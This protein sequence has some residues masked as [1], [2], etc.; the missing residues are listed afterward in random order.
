M[1]RRELLTAAVGAAVLAAVPRL[2]PAHTPY[3]QWL[4]YRKR[5]LLILA[6][7][8][9]AGAF[10]LARA[11]AEALAD[12][13]PDSR[14]RASRAN[15]ADRFASLLGTGQMDVAVLAASDVPLL[16]EGRVPY[17]AAGP[18]AL[19]ALARLDAHMLVSRTDFPAAHAYLVAQALRRGRDHLP[20]ARI[21]LPAD[22]AAPPPHPG[23]VALREG[24][25]PPAGTAPEQA[26][27]PPADDHGHSHPD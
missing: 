4:V 13:L 21:E 24:R 22:G 2:A 1:R 26:P 12:E 17:D 23:V 20:V 8:A 7:K 27:E 14:A 10:P 5:H 3:R 6:N 18:V 15:D 25:P 9:D 11:A 16:E 19:Y